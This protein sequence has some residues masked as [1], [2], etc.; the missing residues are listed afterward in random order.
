MPPSAPTAT[1]TEKRIYERITPPAA[2]A[3]CPAC[4]L[5][6]AS[7]PPPESPS[8]SPCPFSSLSRLPLLD[9]GSW[10]ST[11]THYHPDNPTCYTPAQ[12]RPFHWS[13]RDILAVTDP[14]LNFAVRS[15][16]YSLKLSCFQE[17]SRGGAS[18]SGGGGHFPDCTAIT[19][20]RGTRGR[21]DF[22]SNIE[23]ES[24][25]LSASAILALSVREFARC[26]VQ[27]AVTAFVSDRALIRGDSRAAI[28]PAHLAYGVAGV[29]LVRDGVHSGLP[30]AEVPSVALA[31]S[32][33]TRLPRYPAV[34]DTS[35]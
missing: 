16:L 25:S 24:T 34:M 5:N 27:S 35:C 18:I 2:D 1:P 9:V 8:S 13:P 33:L 11:Q 10:V 15:I 21:V 20:D 19:D 3:F 17:E 31:L 14:T 7:H 29:L 28:S 26:V 22:P 23:Y 32:T 12:Q 30:V 6:S 4:G